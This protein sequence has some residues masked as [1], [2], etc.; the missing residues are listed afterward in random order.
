[1]GIISAIAVFFVIWWTVLFVVLPFGMRVPENEEL[2]L[3][4]QEGTPTNPR[5]GRMA[6]ITTLISIIVF[7]TYYVMTQVV[8]FG[9]DD[10]PSIIPGT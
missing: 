6:L 7:V 8:G 5:I 9:L 4:T 1:M 10:I 3:G 2:R